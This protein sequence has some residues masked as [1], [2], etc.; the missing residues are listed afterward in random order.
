MEKLRRK[1]LKGD[2]EKI[3]GQIIHLNKDLYTI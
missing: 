2:I 3:K 1:R